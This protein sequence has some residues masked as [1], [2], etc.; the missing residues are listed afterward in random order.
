MEFFLFRQI[1]NGISTEAVATGLHPGNVYCDRERYP[2]AVKYVHSRRIRLT[3]DVISAHMC[4]R[5]AK[6]PKYMATWEPGLLGGGSLEEVA[7]WLH[8]GNLEKKLESSTVS[9]GAC[10]HG[11][12]T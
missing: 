4:W 3:A 10:C 7:F 11:I 2:E 1:A 9:R 5:L 8:E 6:W 12:K